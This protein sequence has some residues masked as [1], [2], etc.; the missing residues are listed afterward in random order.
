MSGTRSF[1]TDMSW[2]SSRRKGAVFV[3]D[4]SEVPAGAPTIFSAHGVALPVE[5]RKRASVACPCWY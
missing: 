1:I 5:A 3:E 4:L 2:K